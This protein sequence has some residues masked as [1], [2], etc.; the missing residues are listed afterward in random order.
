V[1]FLV[2]LRNVERLGVVRT[3][4][5]VTRIASGSGLIGGIIEFR[6][7]TKIAN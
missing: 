1:P 4:T 7:F 5:G 2:P 6:K 3:D